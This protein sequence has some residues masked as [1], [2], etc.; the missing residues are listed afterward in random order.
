MLVWPLPLLLSP[1]VGP[2]LA[3]PGSQGQIDQSGCRAAQ[4]WNKCHW[5]PNQLWGKSIATQVNSLS[6]TPPPL[7]PSPPSK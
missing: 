3:W 2:S 5:E 1:R 4:L 7:L 6:L